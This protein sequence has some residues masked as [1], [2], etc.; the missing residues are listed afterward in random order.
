MK[1]GRRVFMISPLLLA[2]I[3]VIVCFCYGYSDLNHHYGDAASNN[4]MNISI[5][6]FVQ[7]TKPTKKKPPHPVN[8]KVKDDIDRTMD[9]HRPLLDCKDISNL[10]IVGII[11]E[12]KKKRTYEVKLP[13]GD[14][15]VLKRC[16]TQW[17]AQRK[18]TEKEGAYLRALHKQYGSQAVAFYGECNLPYRGHFRERDISDFS[19]GYSSVIELGQPL[20]RSWE[21]GR[22]AHEMAKCISDFYTETD[23]EDLRNIARAYANFAE[24]PLLLTN[25]DRWPMKPSD[26]IFPNQY[27]VSRGRIH[28]LDLDMV[29]PCL[30]EAQGQQEECSVNNVLDM[31][32]KVLSRLA[33]MPN[34]DC[35]YPPASASNTTSSST[36]SRTL[37]KAEHFTADHQHINL[38]HAALECK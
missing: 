17:C 13:W 29:F 22:S 32:C 26:N 24:Y 8:N 21:Q 14:H 23:I 35:S 36:T 20:L 4:N 6:E 18:M 27:M 1:G 12:G 31:N 2:P 19:A 16:K 9:I 37:E 11:G 5:E 33:H 3:F 10:E 25:I 7:Q 28:H 15:A 30:K 34:I 38:T